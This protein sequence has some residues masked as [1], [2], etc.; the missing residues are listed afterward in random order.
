MT[1]ATTWD[2]YDFPAWV[3]EPVRGEIR[4]FWSETCGRSPRSWHANTLDKY[5]RQPALG[6]VVEAESFTHSGL[7]LLTGRWV[8]AW[9]NIGRV[10]M[11]DGSYKC[12]S[13]C[14][15]RIIDPATTPP[16]DTP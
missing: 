3:P 16:R 4:R 13:T 6:A 11:R 8:P 14:G 5:N 15:I 10:V 2:A 1:N 7:P 9:N 12:S